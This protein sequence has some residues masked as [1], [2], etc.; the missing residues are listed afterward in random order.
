MKSI[1][2][3]EIGTKIGKLRIDILAYA[4]DIL[5]L[6]ETKI[7]L[8]ILLD[9]LSTL[10]SELEIKFNP[11]KSVY[12]VF[13]PNCFRSS[14]ELATDAW[15]G[16]LLL[17]GSPI[18][19]VKEFRYLGVEIHENN[20]NSSHINKRKKSV[21]ASVAK[22]QSIGLSN[23]NIHPSL[24]AE[25][26]KINIRPILLYG[27]ENLVLNKTELQTLKRI[28]GNAL[29]RILGISTKCKSTD[30]YHALN[31]LTPAERIKWIKLKQF[32]RFTLNEYTNEVLT[33]I[34]HLKIPNTLTDEIRSL[35]ETVVLPEE[36]DLKDK[37]LV[38]IQ[39]IIDA[40]EE[41]SETNKNAALLKLL[42]N[43]SNRDEMK[44][45]I[46]KIL[47]ADRFYYNNQN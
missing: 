41:S 38:S 15:N 43:L 42:F 25:M 4:D 27:F 47:E 32:V 2:E 16:T 13:N 34:D 1:E 37:C 24:Q 23:Y 8:Q 33:V 31:I 46:E 17:A 29:K 9:K 35:T 19:R 36:C 18:E 22:L 10:G 6:A 30:L 26:F 28:E 7:D 5:L 39:D 3:L 20:N 21:L 44:A 45:M 14:N 40:N 11:S 12:M